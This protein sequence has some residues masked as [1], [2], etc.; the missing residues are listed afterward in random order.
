MQIRGV[1]VF[2]RRS[3]RLFLFALALL[4]GCGAGL[5]AVAF[6][7]MISALTELFSGQADYS[8]AGHA[9]NPH[10]EALGRYFVILVPVIAGLIYGPLVWFFAREARGH[11]VP[12]VMLAVARNGGRIRPQVAV[13]KAVA[14]AVCIGGGGSVGREGPIVQI[15][16]ALGSSLG[17]LAKLDE[18]TIRL[19]VACGAA[20]GIAATFNAPLAGVFFAMELILRRW[21]TDSFGMVVVSSVTASVIGRAMLGNHPFLTLPPFQVE[22]VVQY[23]LFAVLALIAGVVGVVFSRILYGVEDVC[24]WV[25]R[26]PEWARPAVGGLLLGLLLLL[27]PEMYG[28]GYPVLGNAVAGQYT[29]LFLLALLVGK[30]AACS[31]TIGI[32]GS[33]GVFAPSLFCGAMLGAA[34]G[35]GIHAII[36]GTGGSIG[37]YALVG[38]GAVFAGA[39][40]A[41]I[42]AA[43]IMFELTGEYTIILPLMLAVVVATAISSVISHDTVY[44]RKLLRRGIDIDEPADAT[45]RRR[46]ITSLIVDPPPA[47]HPDTNL[48]ALAGRF[49]GRTDTT[50]PVIEN[51]GRYLGT[52][53]S[54]DVLDALA[55]ENPT[56]V[57]AL[58][59]HVPPVSEA[60]SLGDILRRLDSGADAVPVAD[61]DGALIGWVRQRDVLAALAPADLD[62]L[63]PPRTPPRTST[64][65]AVAG[66]P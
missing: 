61:A 21:T 11:G 37:A 12:E 43:V 8:A 15:G 31:L 36:P 25:W 48:T 24:D 62:P 6:R 26:G 23:P 5:G 29:V 4:V 58:T 28:V 1:S 50:L 7:H 16:S 57:V 3:N 54:H 39:A 59:T 44:T 18:R 51:N 10:V 56:T 34:F 63:L 19:L 20:G 45:I 41:P 49:A 35:D 14:S 9:A 13:V 22:H 53:T 2:S 65:A 27:L 40:R 33:G 46:P 52:I 38:M 17:Q 47:V 60:A 30:L 55:A 66:Q 32:G 42:T 64:A